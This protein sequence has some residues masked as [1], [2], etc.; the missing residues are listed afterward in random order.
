ME[1]FYESRLC[2][3]ETLIP[4]YYFCSVKLSQNH[5]RIAAE[6]YDLPEWVEQTTDIVNRFTHEGYI[7]IPGAYFTNMVWL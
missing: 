2:G 3:S 6:W 7:K 1:I 4:V 5:I